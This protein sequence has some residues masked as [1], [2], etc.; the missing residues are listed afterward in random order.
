M[1]HKE[2]IE[3]IESLGYTKTSRRLTFD[4]N[5]CMAG[6]F[7]YTVDGMSNYALKIEDKCITLWLESY[8]Y[9]A[10]DGDEELD[11]AYTSQTSYKLTR[12]NDEIIKNTLKKMMDDTLETL[13]EFKKQQRE[14][15]LKKIMEL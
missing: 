13:R 10:E 7:W 3:Y 8:I 14:E 6:C 9:R 15:R 12:Q 1:T 4:N 11:C 5:A 2:L